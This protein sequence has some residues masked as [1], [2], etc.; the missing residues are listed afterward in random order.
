MMRFTGCSL[1]E[2]INL[3]TRNVSR[4]CRLPGVG[5]LEPGKRADLILFEKEG[6]KL[7]I[8]QTLVNGKIV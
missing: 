8:K 2:A 6:E 1:G 4:V 3:A 7:F 5:S